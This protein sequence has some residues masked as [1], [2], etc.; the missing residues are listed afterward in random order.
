MDLDM[1]LNQQSWDSISR[2]ISDAQSV[3]EAKGHSHL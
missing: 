2:N 1:I 3:V